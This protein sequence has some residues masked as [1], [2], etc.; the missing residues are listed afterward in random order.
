[1]KKSATGEFGQH[2]IDDRSPPPVM[3]FR[4]VG[5]WDTVC[6]GDQGGDGQA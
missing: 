6:G 1:M 3:I 5:E 2:H 4:T